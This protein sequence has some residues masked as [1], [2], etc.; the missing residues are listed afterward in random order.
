MLITFDKDVFYPPP[1]RLIWKADRIWNKCR[2]LE[3][4]LKIVRNSIG[5]FFK[6]RL[7]ML[8]HITFVSQGLN[9]N[10][11][12]QWIPFQVCPTLSITDGMKVVS[13]NIY[14]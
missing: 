4:K 1:P 14:D 10:I 3:R 2:T 7:L 11:E 9:I 13:L 12:I 8:L 5:L 6:L